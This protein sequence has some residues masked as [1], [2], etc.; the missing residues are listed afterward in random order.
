V[1]AVRLGTVCRALRIKKHW[2]QE[3]LAARAGVTRQAVS[4]LE[5]GRISTLRVHVVVRIIEALGGNIDFVVRWHG[6]ELDRLIN[7]RHSGLHDSV[8][9]MFSLLSEWVIAPEVSFAIRGERGIIDILA[10]H[11]VTGTLLVIEL[12]TDIVDINELMGRVDRKR[13]LAAVVARERGWQ[14]QSVAVWVVVA[15]SVI[16]RRRVQ[17]HAATLRAAFPAD[18]RTVAG[19]LR[20]PG[21]ALACLSFWSYDRPGNRKSGLAV[22]RR[23]RQAHVA[24]P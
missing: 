16:N 15:D 17:S 24:R 7:V 4:R 9:Q 14:P 12:K 22:T 1:D 11:A 21:S 13:R 5:T 3:D 6:G 23:V 20:R 8:A 2:R 19:W 18:G 10:W